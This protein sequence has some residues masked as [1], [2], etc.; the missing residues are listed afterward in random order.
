VADGQHASSSRA[1]YEENR[2]LMLRWTIARQTQQ[3]GYATG[4]LLSKSSVVQPYESG[5]SMNSYKA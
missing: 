2:D 4:V 5:M 1:A 3:G